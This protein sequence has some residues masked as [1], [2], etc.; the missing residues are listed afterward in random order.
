[1]PTL[2]ELRAKLPALEGLDD[3]HAVEFI[4]RVYYPKVDPAVI[5]QSLGVV[6]PAPPKP[7]RSMMRAGADVALSGARGVGT[8]VRMLT[9]L[10]GADN[11][12]S[13]GLRT[14]DEAMRGL[15]SERAHADE[16]EVGQIMQDAEGKGVLDQIGAAGR[17]FMVAPVSMAANAAGTAVP[18]I[19][20]AM[21]PG[22]QALMASRLAGAGVG[23]AQGVG[24]TKG[25]IYDSTKNALLK[26]GA[27]PEEAEARA[28]ERQE[29]ANLSAG[30]IGGAAALG[31]VAGSSG[32]ERIVGRMGA[33]AAGGAVRRTVGGAVTEAI[34]EAAQGGHE[35]WSANTALDAEGFDRDPMAGVVAQ[36]ALEGMASM[37]VG[38]AFGA[39]S[40]PGDAV[41]EQKMPE[42]GPLSRALNAGVEAQ[43]QEVDAAATAA[44]AATA[45][46]TRRQEAAP[47]AEL[48]ATLAPEVRDEA[49]G[50]LAVSENPRT[51]APVRR[52]AMNRLDVL[53]Y[54]DAA[55]AP[56]PEAEGAPIEA[57][58]APA[59]VEPAAEPEAEAPVA[60]TIKMG[61]QAPEDIVV[62]ATGKPFKTMPAA[63]RAL[64]AAGGE[65]THEFVRVK[66]GLVVRA[67]ESS[68]V[69]I[70]DSAVQGL[71]GGGAAPDA[72]SFRG[73]AADGRPAGEPE[74]PVPAGVE[75]AAA[76]DGPGVLGLGG[77]DGAL[78]PFPPEAGGL[79]VPRAEMPQIKSEHHGALVQF[80]QARGVGHETVEVD[81]RQLKPTQAEFDAAKVRSM[82]DEPRGERSVL[83]SSDGHVIDGHHQTLAAAEKGE[84]LKV[85]RFDKPIA[86]MLALA[87]E[88][89][90]SATPAAS[91]PEPEAAP[92]PSEPASQAK[93]EAMLPPGSYKPQQKVTLDGREWTVE[94]VAHT[95]REATITSTTGKHERRRV[96][97]A[98][99][100]P[101]APEADNGAWWNAATPEQRKA[102]AGRAGWSV[103]TK[104][105]AA[106]AVVAKPW[107]KLSETQRA[108]LGAAKDDDAN[109]PNDARGTA[110][111]AKADQAPAPAGGDRG[112]EAAVPAAA[113]PAAAEAGGVEPERTPRDI[114]REAGER[115]DPR[116]PPAA[117]K[118][119]DKQLWRAGW[120]E[121]KKTAVTPQVPT[122]AKSTRADKAHEARAAARRD[123][124]TPGSIVDSYGG[125]DR[126][127]EYTDKDSA[128][129]W[130]VKVQAV[131][132]KGD[133]WVDVPREQPRWHST[134][135]DADKITRG[136]VQKAETVAADAPSAPA[137]LYA[138]RKVLNA[139]AIID[140]AASQGFTSTLKADDLHVT[141]AYSRA[142]VDG[143][144]AG[145]AA[146]SV[147]AK[148]GRRSVEPLGDEG[149]V[150]LKFPSSDM[151]ARWQQYRD[152]GAS[153]DY[154]SYTPHVTLTYDGK[155]VDLSK[156]QVYRGPIELGPETQAALNLD[157]ADD[158]KEAGEASTAPGS[159]KARK[160]VHP[161]TIM[162][163]RL[164]ALVSEKRG[165]IASSML[166]SI[167]FRFASNRKGKDGKPLT[168]WRN[169]PV[170][171]IGPL[172][173]RGGTSDLQELAEL[174][175][176]EGFL[177][178]GT[179]AA[180]AKDAG[181]QAI[182]LIRTALERGETPT[183]G[184]Q[185]AD[186]EA[187]MQAEADAYYAEL[188][189]ESAAEAE[190]E[191]QS[192][193][194]DAG[195]APER[196]DDA[197][198]D[199]P[200][201]EEGTADREAGMR[202]LGF[203]E[204]EIEDGQAADQG[205]G[206]G[207][208]ARPGEARAQEVRP[209][210]EAGN[211]A[212]REGDTEGL[213]S[214]TPESLA[215]DA[216]RARASEAADRAEQ[217]RLS[218]KA[219]ADAERGEFTLTGSDRPADV[220]AA[221]GQ[222]DIFAAPPSQPEAPTKI[223][224]VGEKIGGAR[225]DTAE[226]TGPRRAR[227][228][229]DDGRPAWARRFEVSQIV[230]PGGQISAMRDEGRW[231]LRDTRSKDWMGQP[232]QVGRDTFATKEDAEAFVP[233]AAVGLKHRPV[234][235]SNGKYEIWRDITD[236]KR[237]KVVD[238]SFDTREDA[239]A[240]MAANAQQIIE[241]NTTFGEADIPLPPD[242]KRTGPE[243]RTGNVTGDDFK[244]TF[245]FRGV[246]FGLWN[247][248][249]ERQA[250]MNDA[251]D[252]LMDLADV[253]GV[254]P[255]ALG[256][257]GDLAL[258]FGARGH[259]L[260]SARAHYERERAVI[261]L[262][263]ERGAGSLA[264]EWFHGM[265][266]YFG[267]QDGKAS[268]QWEVQKDGTR[269][270]KA[271]DRDED[272]VSHGFGRQ[273]AVREQ[274]RKPYDALIQT[275]FKKAATYVE[276][277]AKADT[278]SARAK[279][280][281][282]GALDKLRAELSAQKDPTYWKRN[283]KPASAEQLTEFDAIAKT[284]IEG[285]ATAIGTEWRTV[286]DLN[287]PASVRAK[288]AHR[289][290]ND[291]LERLSAIYKDVR[292]RSG[293]DGTNRDGVFD[294]LRGYMERYSQR[295]KM[296]ADAQSGI[297]KQRMM[298]TDFAMNAK[299]L[300]QGR[301]TDYWTT[302]HEM[303]A[304]A[305][306]GYVEDKVAERGGVSRFLNYGP[307]NVGILTPWGVK[308]PFPAG[309]ERKAINAAFDAF[310][311]ELKTRDS[312][313]GVALY[314][315]SLGP[316][317]TILQALSEADD[318]FALPRLKG[319]TVSEI[320]FDLDPTI[321]VQRQVAGPGQRERW[322]VIFPEGGHA[323]I[324][325]RAPNPFGPTLYG[326]D[327]ADGEMVNP[328][329]E[330]PGDNHDDVPAA[331]EDVILDASPMKEGQH[332][333]WAYAIAGAL[334][335][336][337]GRIF[338]GD[339]AGL[340]DVALRRRSEN[341]LS[342]A[343]RY[344]TSDFLGPHPR[345][346]TGDKALGVPPL[347]WVYGDDMGNIERLIA[348]NV[349]A[350]E[351]ASPESKVLDFDVTTGSFRN[352]E[353]R[354]SLGRA[355]LESGTKVRRE[356]GSR[357]LGAAAAGGRTTARAAVWRALA[358]EAS[359]R[360]EGEGGRVGLLANLGADGL[361]GKE[362]SGL[363]SRGRALAP[364]TDP[365]TIRAAA[366]AFA[367]AGL[368][369]V[370]VAATAADLPADKRERLEA[371]GI[372]GARGVYF[373]DSDEIWLVADQL[374]GVEDASFVV[375]H[376]A[377]H[378]GLRKLFPA[379][380]PALLRTM[381]RSNQMLRQRTAAV[382]TAL[383][384]MGRDEAIEEALA[385]MAG[386]G[387]AK[388]LKGFDKL[389]A[390]IR[391]WLQKLATALGVELQFTD[392]MI[393]KFVAGTAGEG[394]RAAPPE[395][396][397]TVP[398]VHRASRAAT[399]LRG[400]INQ[401]QVRDTLADMLGAAGSKV[402]W[403]DKTL[404]TQYAKAERLP[405]FKQ[406]FDSVQSYLEDVSTLANT[407]AD[408]APQ[409]LPKLETWRD[410][411]NIGI[412]AADSKAIA[413]PVFEGTLNYV[414]EAGKLLTVDEA[415]ARAEKL[416][417]HDKAQRLL[418]DGHFTEA[419]LKAW[420]ASPLAT[421]DA[422]V[423]NRYEREYLAAGVVFTDAELRDLFKLDDKQIG[424]YKQF[425]AAVDA[426]LDHVAASEALRLIGTE[427]PPALKALAL[428]DPQALRT[429]IEEMLAD[430]PDSFDL[431]ND[432]AD[433]FNKVERLKRQG[434]AP[435]MRFGKYKVHVSE[436]DTG[437]TLFFG[438]YE[439]RQAANA[440]VRELRGDPEFAKARFE[441]GVLSQKAYE[442]F[443]GVPTESL[444]MFASAIGA[445][446]SEVF[447]QYLRLTKNNRSALKRLI[448]RK[449]TAGFS[450][451]V[452]RV[453]ASFVT[454]NSRLAAAGMNLP[455]ANA[456]AEGIREGDVQDEAVGLIQ[457]AQK[458]AE[459]AAGLRGLMFMNFIGGSIASALVNATQP[460]TMTLPYLTQWGG[461]AKATARLMGAGKAVATGSMDAA[462]RAALKRAE[463]EGI[464]SP[465]EIH[466]LRA[467]A[468]AS[469]GAHPL[470]RR[471]AFIWAAPFSLAEQWNRRVSFV[472]AFNT[473]R[474]QGM[475]DPFA[476]S[477][478]AVM[479]TQGIYCVDPETECLTVAGWK[480]YDQLVAG[481]AVYALDAA[482]NLVESALLNVHVHRRGSQVIRLENATGFSMVLTPGHDCLVQNF[483]N[484]GK[485]WRAPRKVKASDLRHQQVLRVP[486][487][488]ATGRAASYSND[489][490]MLLA[491]VAAEGSLFA[492]RNCVVKRGVQIVQSLTHNP[493][494]VAEIDAL[495]DRLGG[496]YSRLV[497]K[498][499]AQGGQMVRWKL[500]KPLWSMI[501]R[502]LPE[503]IITPEL[504]GALTVQ[505]MRLFLDTFVKGDGHRPDDG[506]AVITQRDRRNC[507]NLQAMA[508]LSGQ[509][510]SLQKKSGHD[511]HSLY[512]AKN[513]VRAYAKELTRSEGFEPMVWCPETAHGTWIARRG[514]R[515]FVTGNSKGNAPNLARGPVGA[516]A[517]QFK[518]YSIHYLEWLTRMYRS[519]PEG[520]K[521]VLIALAMLLAVG[522]A[523][524]LPFAEDIN[525]LAD[526]LTQALGLDLG[527]KEQ[528][529]KFIAEQLGLGDMAA[530]V[531]LRGLSSLPGMP[532]D[533]SI[534]MGMGSLIPG[535]GLLLRS[536][537][538]RSRDV[539]EVVGPIGGAATQY[540]DAALLAIGGDVKEGVTKA[541][542]TAAQNVAK[543]VGMWQSGEARDDRGRKVMP[544]GE[545]D[546]L[547]RF[548]GFNPAAIAA[549]SQRLGRIRRSEQLAKNVEGDIVERW[550]RG[551]VDGEP[552]KVQ[553]ARDELAEWNR[554]NPQSP[555]RVTPQQIRN[556]VRAMRQ[557]RAERFI[558]SVSPE[559]RG[560]VADAVQ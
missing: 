273:S 158:Y 53:L 342:L 36:G 119:A 521:A 335:H 330:R 130:G 45:P 504:V 299:E 551:V 339:P 554:D 529:R 142:P 265:D 188:D 376:E 221:A 69:G 506:G 288:I 167:S 312:D 503:K 311:A 307:E 238:Q 20:A 109:Q 402:S 388:N 465:Q 230:R 382:M 439:T 448:H 61:V 543:A 86:D 512:L 228:A 415:I 518:Q 184:E 89:P 540:K 202:A 104:S 229:E 344:G 407:A 338:I 290:T 451:D 365:A 460:I 306:Q 26:A 47:T 442:L 260:N 261:N 205:R 545:V 271:R 355:F 322:R 484:R 195:V 532:M 217:K 154:E 234:L 46:Q 398:A 27:S 384:G 3:T 358:R 93:P 369:G 347:K 410:M 185:Q 287:Q 327:L 315:R 120:D 179:V 83:V 423:E 276:D 270:L 72:D 141:V 237:V 413:A 70:S 356:R 527:L 138:S 476:F 500:R 331:T 513:S 363:F 308:R 25:S 510:S 108:R 291:S 143:A 149:A 304:R 58:S 182:V 74:Q 357:S 139:Q 140:W 92:A 464:V 505:Q 517:L 51:P 386:E 309:D 199:V 405:A 522:G 394:L 524:G 28:A 422:A 101:A 122:K 542:P 64:Q 157:K 153:W 111:E 136:P 222:G 39:M 395:F 41:R 295:L 263:K 264:H 129:R 6:P 204:Q 492:H 301:G 496:H 57:P 385:D 196:Y 294:K 516:L 324:S 17:A 250:L 528:K 156:V 132:K 541:L 12:V 137:P 152:A 343:L 63:M 146:D 90:S 348:L 236:R 258:A 10:A 252:G 489:E 18:T 447:Q 212:A 470:L 558:K 208:A 477:R 361:A 257:D 321:K 362:L 520:K 91:Q 88:F 207:E 35:Q 441:Q 557:T 509:T 16:A 432:I 99:Q 499:R 280:E 419:Q 200:W 486:L 404:A 289:W 514:G 112:Q 134:E 180:D 511:W 256:L 418:R 435:L 519:G 163:S 303:A 471:I 389:V 231:V 177:P 192:I 370:K 78:T 431:W 37:P 444:E 377:F 43:A 133:E 125:H 33:P 44:T 462:T 96:G 379:D 19:A 87:R 79:G 428:S 493:A 397:D 494:H 266:H 172:F 490:V 147:V 351:N 556:R 383:P 433:K 340:S 408:A 214:P 1:M 219:K 135:P 313:K 76:A 429:A 201:G 367:D 82:I 449:G 218:D 399:A 165:G 473:A 9:D 151:Q 548:L 457:A 243:R 368:V 145:K 497:G 206:E 320:A 190:A 452:P 106:A 495:L 187:T 244:D 14:A 248:Q 401:Q 279:D 68:N 239:L 481:E 537:T 193:M 463:D 75:P 479:E 469:F 259:G 430:D 232:R 461:L 220:A 249:D 32:V 326:F 416:S 84:P 85:I 80:T 498:A 66:D 319:K 233:I 525:D 113:A 194:A 332:G 411:K 371:A 296:L 400:G 77:G 533:V 49:L 414:R 21:L 115:G 169:P 15:Q 81:P 353:S 297:E 488:D 440:M 170:P 161:R 480:R 107:E 485:R 544:A 131:V 420:R 298:P 223:E 446:K 181:E 434:Y 341:M 366:A 65:A 210:D 159:K 275:M 52:H 174:L 436:P 128:G 387:Q 171:G 390:L 150:V 197:L 549:E 474:E 247:N 34:P 13:Q 302:P 501:L 62:K 445:D 155:G 191:R 293:F 318:L 241:A 56:P 71:D 73:V 268:A 475:A 274:L 8:G 380:A 323:D 278:F 329:H 98:D 381:W 526:T 482:G 114:G 534:R 421:H 539:L 227:A 286:G 336:N 546:G 242:R 254:P 168:Q 406:V 42:T 553:A 255:K 272:Y 466:H 54:G 547:M 300:D 30:Q 100:P 103:D 116:D 374:K 443:A 123:Y 31:A 316:Q 225:K 281:L 373:P 118:N 59:G 38:G 110:P 4:Q 531:V 267:R 2:A 478:K 253:L 424:L 552:D 453:L 124:F 507:D 350:V 472:A 360:G 186:A 269:R 117:L 437:E 60:P 310:V 284:M 7:E 502:A 105:K 425:R 536:N 144:K 209:A 535:T 538:D 487:G 148:G 95:G 346:V 392:A 189:A 176:E 426:S 393:E 166:S 391:S 40:R 508:V 235:A 126:V 251:W 127:L 333:D 375:V 337:T 314:S 11:R 211:D 160:P 352:T 317:N 467:Q 409:I 491:W 349:A 282:A 22:G 262:T 5:A 455:A 183:Q 559:R 48:L 305:F 550:A 24:A 215:A 378:R 175:E 292:G 372:E 283:N 412:G 417:V 102:V 285:E 121:S 277:T 364:A 438:L 173:R 328:V 325:V 403:F 560:A 226:S 359:R 162:G 29:Y 354:R 50:L 456:A 178:T 468:S 459:A 523:E 216:E 515:T 55:I 555:M 530:D 345:Q 97:I 483:D 164:L 198:D 427:A 23:A 245:G 240:Y 396:Q 224:D 454:S 458:P 334:A 246:E 94:A 213:T 203:T 67:K 450:D